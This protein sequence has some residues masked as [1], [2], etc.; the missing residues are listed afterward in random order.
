VKI[1]PPGC[2]LELV[3][4]WALVA[5]VLVAIVAAIRL[6]LDLIR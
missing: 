2:W 4:S 6:V 1:R 5:A 3:S